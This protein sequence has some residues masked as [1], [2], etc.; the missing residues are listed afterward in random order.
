MEA[1]SG[2]RTAPASGVAGFIMFDMMTFLSEGV[3]LYAPFQVQ[4]GQTV[5]LYTRLVAPSLHHVDFSTMEC[6]PVLH[7]QVTG[8]ESTYTYPSQLHNN[9]AVKETTFLETALRLKLGREP[10][11]PVTLADMRDWPARR[12]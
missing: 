5:S 4:R 9:E 6:R 11:R 8:E 10:G 1:A 2:T 12:G 7:S 3:S